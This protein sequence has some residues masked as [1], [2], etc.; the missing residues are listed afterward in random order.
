MSLSQTSKLNIFSISN[1]K[2]L[3]HDMATTRELTSMENT[4]N[5]KLYIARRHHFHILSKHFNLYDGYNHQDLIQKKQN[6]VIYLIP[7]PNAKGLSEDNKR[8]I[9]KYKGIVPIFIRH[10]DPHIPKKFDMNLLKS[11]SDC[12]LTYVDSLVDDENVFFSNMC[13]DSHLYNVFEFPPQRERLACM[14]ANNRVGKGFSK[15]LKEFQEYNICAQTEREHRRKVARYKDIDI[16]GKGGWNPLMPNYYGPIKP[17]DQK[18]L[19]LSKYRFDFVIDT[20]SLDTYVS[21]K[22]LD[23]FLVPTVPVYLGTRNISRFIPKKCYISISDF[24]SYDELLKYLDN[25][26]YKEYLA[27]YNNIMTERMSIFENFT[28]KNN[29]TKRIYDWYN[30]SYFTNLGPSRKELDR[31]D[32]YIRG[33]SLNMSSSFWSFIKRKYTLKTM[34]GRKVLRSLITQK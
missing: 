25:M 34:R 19:I 3:S 16:Y 17:Y 18:Y 24:D 26:S 13:F 33:L 5:T 31:I 11:Y 22:I 8:I 9:S 1:R 4:E 23:S 28:T 15:P 10:H 29:V 12:V 7:D 2:V 20:V 21:E 27:Y 6:S 32:N 30:K 14:I